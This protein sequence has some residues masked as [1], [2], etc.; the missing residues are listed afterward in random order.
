M[1]DGIE[2]CIHDLDPRACA[3]CNPPSW[4][5]PAPRA[6]GGLDGFYGQPE[7]VPGTV[8]GP[9]F[10][11]SYYGSCADCG[12]PTEPDDMIRSDGDSGWLCQRCGELDGDPAPG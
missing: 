9:W 1:A 12:C 7:T 5:E 6:P 10:P 3:D 4:R 8:Y 2:L 11:A